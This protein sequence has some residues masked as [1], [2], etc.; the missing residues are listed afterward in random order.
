MRSEGAEGN[1]GIRVRTTDGNAIA[2]QDY[3]P[4]DEEI[5]F[6][7]KQI[8]HVFTVMLKSDVNFNDD[9]TFGIE[10]IE[11]QNVEGV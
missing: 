8:E 11:P 9:K 3:E 6:E 5:F 2:N 4:I 7:D 1:I 10:L